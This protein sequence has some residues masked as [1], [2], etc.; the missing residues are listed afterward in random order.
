MGEPL[1]LDIIDAPT[2]WLLVFDREAASWWSRLIACGRYKHVR[3]F[4]YIHELGAYVFYDVQFSGTRIQLARG[5]GARALMLEWTA[6]ADV[7]RYDVSFSAGLSAAFPLLF[8]PF[9]CT[10]AV[11]HLVGLPGALRPDAFYRQ[12]LQN[13]AVIVHGRTQGTG[14]TAGPDARSA[15][16]D[17]V[18]SAA[19][20]AAE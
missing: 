18:A 19:D 2:R 8:R 17:G 15:D 9:L 20:R 1:L 12:C 13:G 14:T 11:A 4:G 6:N 5:D 7:L 3:T 16:G 10:T